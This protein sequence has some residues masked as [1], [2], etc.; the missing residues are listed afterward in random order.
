[1][2]TNNWIK[3]WLLE[4]RTPQLLLEVDKLQSF[5]AKQFQQALR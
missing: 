3:F 2:P 5:D 4:L 1:V